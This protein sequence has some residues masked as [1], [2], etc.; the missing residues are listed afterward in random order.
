MSIRWKLGTLFLSLVL[1]ISVDP[2]ASAQ[3]VKT[4]PDGIVGVWDAQINNLDCNTGA[5]L[6]S[7]RGLHKYEL[8]G[9]AQV[10]PATNPALLSAH[11]GTWRHV[12]GSNYQL[13]IKMFR[14]DTAGNSVGWNVVKFNVAIN[15][16]GTA[17][18]GSG[19]SEVFDSDGNSL[20]TTCPQFTG[21][22]FV[23]E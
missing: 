17:E 20:A 10:V 14:F 16:D 11:V 12:Q 2:L 21:T 19:Q 1:I 4:R 8:G 15:K 23:G 6:A 13:S 18:A 9:T 7:F 22:R 3:T 5:L